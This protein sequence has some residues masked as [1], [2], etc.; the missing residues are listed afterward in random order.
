MATLQCRF[1]LIDKLAI[2][3]ILRWQYSGEYM[4]YNALLDP[5]TADIDA[6]SLEFFVNPHNAYAAYDEAGVL[7][8]FCCFGVDAQVPGGDYT[9]DALDVGLGLRPDLTG[10]GLGTNFLGAILAL[11]Q[12][13]F[14][15]LPPRATIAAFNARSQ[16]IFAKNGF[17]TVQRF[18][19]RSDPPL[20]FVVMV[21][22]A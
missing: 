4:L 16:R 7:I 22:E 19:S 20:A 3:T 18:M 17:Q 11:A 1:R 9:E 21:K 13:E 10:Q 15:P 6:V 8:G 2:Q 5:E 12:R 14:D